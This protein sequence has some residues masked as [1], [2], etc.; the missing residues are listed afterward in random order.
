MPTKTIYKYP[1]EITDEQL[2]TAPAGWQP[3]SV[4]M[5]RNTPCIW[6]L[7]DPEAPPVQQKVFVNGT[8]H[9]VERDAPFLGTIQ[10][11]PLVFHVFAFTTA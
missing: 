5:Q 4:Q 7:V 8:G 11:G 9:P 10:V 6:A 1:I 3:L 2:V